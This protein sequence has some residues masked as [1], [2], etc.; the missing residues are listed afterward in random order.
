[1]V[2]NILL[3]FYLC[4][5][6]ASILNV[7]CGTALRRSLSISFPVTRQIPYV[8]FSIRIRACFRSLI[9]FSCLPAK[10]A[11][12]SL[13][14]ISAPSSNALKVGEVSSVPLFWSLMKLSLISAKSFSA[15]AIF[16]RIIVLN[17]CIL[18][19]SLL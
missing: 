14:R 4:I 9:N 6:F 3:M 13:L 12:C 10:I 15:F 5:F 17:F 8:L 2:S 7:A 1:M 11:F 19:F 16:S 18:H